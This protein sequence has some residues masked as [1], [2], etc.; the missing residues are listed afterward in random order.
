MFDS[1]LL[2]QDKRSEYS[3]DDCVVPSRSRTPGGRCVT[4]RFSM[5][6]F[7]ELISI[8]SKTDQANL[9]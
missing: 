8:N 2:T 9:V 3:I 4:T 1:I 5:F 6:S 7:D